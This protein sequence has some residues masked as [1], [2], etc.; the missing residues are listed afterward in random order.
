MNAVR[1]PFI[2]WLTG[3]ALVAAGVW[4][5][6]P[7]IFKK[8]AEPQYQTAV[9]KRQDIVQTV[10]ASG[11]LSAIVTVEVGSQI[12]GIIQ[13]LVADYNTPVKAG[14]VIAQLDPATYRATKNQAEGELANARA[15]LELA[16]LNEKRQQELVTGNAGTQADLDKAVADLDQAKAMVMMRQAQLD[17]ATVDLDRC[18]I[19][20][21]VDGIVI[22]RDVN[23]GQT[24]AAAMTAPKLFTIA[25]D[26]SKMQIEANVSEADIGGVKE[27]QEAEFTVDAFAGRTFRG[28]VKMVR[29]API[30]VENVVTYVTVIE[31]ANPKLELRPGMTANVSIVLDK[32]ENVLAVP[33][34]ALRFKPSQKNASGPPS[35]SR[36]EGRPG[37]GNGGGPPSKRVYVLKDG[38]PE[39]VEV[40]TGLTDGIYTEITGGLT[41]GGELI[42]NQ[43]TPGAG[44]SGPPPSSG[45]FGGRMPHR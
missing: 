5:G 26:L 2:P 1:F 12:S 36:G 11:Q 6:R 30:T 7:L 44:P 34:S 25:N 14:Q 29:F 10:T 43:F 31:V 37:G 27:G 22:S 41:E 15:S 9:A 4:F 16:R 8:E 3:I 17:R 23:E 24:V 39:P 20:A 18:T 42:T 38:Q 13:K 33:N 32:R 45:S 35:G 28:M 19:T 21:P 40:T